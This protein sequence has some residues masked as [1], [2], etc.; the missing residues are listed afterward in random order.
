MAINVDYYLNR[1]RSTVTSVAAQVSNALP[2]NPVTRDYEILS[3]VGSAGPAFNWKVYAAQKRSTK[4]AVSV[5]LFEKR[6][7]EKWPRYERELFLEIMKRGVSQLTRLRHPRILVIEHPLEESRDSYAF[8]TEPVFASLANALGRLDNITPHPAHLDEFELLDIEIRY[9]LFQVIEALSFLHIDVRMMHRNISPESVMINEKGEWKLAGFDF[10]AQGTQ[11]TNSQVVYEMLEWNQRTM[12]VVQPLLDYLAPEYVI[13]GRCDT[14]A[15][16]FSFGIMALT[17]FNRGKQPFDNR[18]SL[19]NFRRNIGK[20][21]TLPVSIFVNVPAEVR[22]DLKMCLN[23]TPDLRPDAT[24]FSKIIYFDEPLIRTLNSLDSLCQMDY[25]QKMN[26]FK[27]LPQFLVKFPKRPLIQ[28]I[29]PQLCAEFIATELV[30][31]ILPSVFHIVGIT[32]NDEFTA[33]VLPQLVPI[34]TLERPYQILLLFLQ[35]MDLL[36]QKTSEEDARKYLLPLICNALSSETVKIQE[37]CLSI[38]P[39]VA[40]MIE[41]QSMKAE[42]L[43]KLLLLIVDGGGVL[44]IRVQALLCIGKLLPS[45]EPWMVTDQIIPALPKVV[46]REPA[47]LMA[48]LGIYKLA[49][50]E[51]RI[52]IT[53]EQCAKSILP[54]L[55]ASSMENALNM[56]QFEQY[57]A[58]IHRILDRIEKEQRQ[59]LQQLSASQEEQR[60]IGEFASVFGQPAVQNKSSLS[61]SLS[62]LVIDGSTDGA[63]NGINKN[64]GLLSLADKKRLAAAQEQSLR[65]RNQPKLLQPVSSEESI[66]KNQFTC[67]NLVTSPID[68]ALEEVGCNSLIPSTSISTHQTCIDL[69]DFFPAS[70][71]TKKV[72][73]ES[74]LN[75]SDSPLWPDPFKTEPDKLTSFMFQPT[76]N[77]VNLPDPPVV[78]NP[79]ARSSSNQRM[80]ANRTGNV[81]LNEVDRKLN[82]TALDDIVC[83]PAK[84]N[85]KN[86]FSLNS[87][88]T[89]SKQSNLTNDIFDD[90]L[91]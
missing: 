19:D 32:N 80:T 42:V 7:L 29:L 73:N 23:L 30:P 57:M 53:R 72:E 74:I 47:I 40:T 18:N 22:D 45:L 50:E 75:N 21:N 60:S 11:G 48:I 9:G 8:C 31:F 83:F 25:T 79:V 90:L 5:W 59:R 87:Q 10:S 24:Q 6:N 62:D 86:N 16:M 17:V 35:N 58:L 41:R 27:Q 67:S 69:S 49:Y 91:G 88:I 77:I 63:L 61:G 66:N 82:M 12:S 26:F 15:D 28:K 65:M 20:L 76:V 33:A 13:G 89:H 4:K 70:S 85:G 38:V 52:G 14:Y 43:P 2:G 81:S 78:Q 1:I 51:S 46:S 44:T 71:F 64:T 54:F 84:L 36:L 34:F 37:L 39:K 68:S 56:P 3:Q 55:I